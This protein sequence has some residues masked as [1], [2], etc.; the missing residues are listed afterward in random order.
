[1]AAVGTVPTADYAVLT[2]RTEALERL[3]SATY[4]LVLK[5][6]TLAAG[7]G[8]VICQDER[9]AQAAVEEMFTQRRFGEPTS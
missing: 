6:D 8:V 5:A 7:K 1:M 4:P 9:E 2:S 3:A